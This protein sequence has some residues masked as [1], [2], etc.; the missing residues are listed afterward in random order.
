MD[1]KEIFKMFD[2]VDEDVKNT[3]NTNEN[4]GEFIPAA[5]S[6]NTE[7]ISRFI[8]ENFGI[9]KPD[10]FMD[11]IPEVIHVDVFCAHP[12]EEKPYYVIM[13]SGLSE[14]AMK[15]E[16][17]ED[18]RCEL[19]M[20][21]PKDWNIQSTAST[22]WNWPISVLKQ[23]ARCTYTSDEALYEYSCFKFEPFAEN[24]ELCALLSVRPTDEKLRFITGADGAVINVYIAVPIYREELDFTAANGAEALLEKIFG[25]VNIPDSAY[26]IDTDRINSCI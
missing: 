4:C 7:Y 22:L 3:V 16:K 9:S 2:Y 19:M 6:S 1:E 17:N 26:V 24:T 21:L 20:L 10:V 11:L 18:S 12:T 14:Y 15:C 23:A 5:Y 25:T 8:C 13:T